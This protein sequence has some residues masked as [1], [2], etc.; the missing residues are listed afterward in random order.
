MPNKDGHIVVDVWVVSQVFAKVCPENPQVGLSA[1]VYQ[2]VVVNVVLL[3]ENGQIFFCFSYIV[4][5]ILV[6]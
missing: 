1:T 5:H 6:F 2:Y 4:S 3:V